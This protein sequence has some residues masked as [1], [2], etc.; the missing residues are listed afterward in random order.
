MEP[1]KTDNSS[2]FERWIKRRDGVMRGVLGMGA[3]PAG[4]AEDERQ[5]RVWKIAGNRARAGWTDTIGT[6]AREDR[7]IRRN[8][9]TVSR[10][11][12]FLL[13]CLTRGVGTKAKS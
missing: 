7:P 6:G 2:A 10:V 5:V 8:P 11:W 9:P 13:S 4:R 1:S 12:L 3:A